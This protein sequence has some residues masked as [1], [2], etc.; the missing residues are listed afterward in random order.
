[1]L[2]PRRPVSRVRSLPVLVPASL[3]LV[4]LGVASPEAD[5]SNCARL[6]AVGTARRH[7]PLLRLPLWPR[8]R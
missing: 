3:A 5:A 4:G 7:P 1:M 6:R 8:S 2:E